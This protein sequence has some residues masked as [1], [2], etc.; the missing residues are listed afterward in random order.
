MDPFEQEIDERRAA[1]R[2]KPLLRTIYARFY[3][4]LGARLNP[5]TTLE[6]GSGIGQIR[7][8]LPECTTSDVFPS[9]GIDQVESAY[10]LSCADRSL[11]NLILLDVW[12]HLQFPGAAL[13]EFHRVLARGG[14]VVMLEPAMGLFPRVV[15]RLFHHE[16]LGFR[17]QIQWEPAVAEDLRHLTYFAAQSRAW[18]V[19][20]RGEGSG[21]L[22]GWRVAECAAWSDL[23][24]LASGGFSRHALYPSFWL[25]QIEALDRMLTRLS[26]GLFAARL[27]IV[28]EKQ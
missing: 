28:L 2:A 3:A 23:A 25:P 7:E 8:F 5:G 24:Y 13:R 6:L 17:Q 16:P 15:Y 9:T 26:A 10:A 14:R 12:H 21:H 22:H 4:T 1:W 19:F 18:R 20:V 27:L 11:H